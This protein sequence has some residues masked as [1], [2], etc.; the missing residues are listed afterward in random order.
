MG[1][2]SKEIPILDITII[3]LIFLNVK[4][5]QKDLRLINQQQVN[6]TALEWFYPTLNRDQLYKV[7]WA[8]Q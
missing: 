6:W 2:N 5:A 7:Q 8:K 3:T 1:H 4:L